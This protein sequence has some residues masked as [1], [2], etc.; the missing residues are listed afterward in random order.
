VGHSYNWRGGWCAKLWKCVNL[1]SNINYTFCHNP[2]RTSI[3]IELFQHLLILA[4]FMYIYYVKWFV[5]YYFWYSF[6]T[7]IEVWLWTCLQNRFEYLQ[8]AIWFSYFTTTTSTTTT[9]TA[10]VQKLSVIISLQKHHY[11]SGKQRKNICIWNM[12][13]LFGFFNA[14]WHTDMMFPLISCVKFWSHIW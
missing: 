10:A 14:Y 5:I 8:D 13:D 1:Y 4:E 12:C 7:H 11:C 2:Q 9:T 6:V 3:G